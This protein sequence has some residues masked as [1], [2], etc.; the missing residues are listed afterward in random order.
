MGVIKRCL[1]MATGKY[2]TVHVIYDFILVDTLV[3]MA[4]VT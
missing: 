2:Y 1:D 3:K 4:F